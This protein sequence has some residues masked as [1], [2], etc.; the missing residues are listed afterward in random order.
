MLWQGRGGYYRPGILVGQTNRL[1]SLNIPRV[2]LGAGN[3]PASCPSLAALVVWDPPP[4]GGVNG[5]SQPRGGGL[6]KGDGNRGNRRRPPSR[7]L[8]RKSG[9]R[10]EQRAHKCRGGWVS[11]FCG[12]IIM[13]HQNPNEKGTRAW[14]ATLRGGGGPLFVPLANAGP[15]AVRKHPNMLAHLEVWVCASGFF[16]SPEGGSPALKRIRCGSVRMGAGGPR[17]GLDLWVLCG[18]CQPA[19]RLWGPGVP[20]SRRPGRGWAAP[21]AGTSLGCGSAVGRPGTGIKKNWIAP[22]HSGFPLQSSHKLMYYILLGVFKLLC[23]CDDFWGSGKR[24]ISYGRYAE[25]AE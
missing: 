3:E 20:A 12:E 19:G 7:T 1:L 13:V 10:R 18:C 6:G 14:F 8:G 21:G 23:H 15:S 16:W 25:G 22:S 17:V 5:L 24:R 9:M 4:S 11:D 2:I